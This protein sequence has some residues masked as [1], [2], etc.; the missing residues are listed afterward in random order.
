MLY[1]SIIHS[2]L[3]DY[4]FIIWTHHHLLIQLLMDVWAIINK[5]AMNT[6]VQVFARK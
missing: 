5:A 2:F 3:V 4:Y 1:V 6:V